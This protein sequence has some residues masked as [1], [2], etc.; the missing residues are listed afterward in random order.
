MAQTESSKYSQSIESPPNNL[1]NNEVGG[2]VR[3]YKEKAL[4]AFVAGGDTCLLG[5]KVPSNFRLLSLSATNANINEVVS[6]D[7]AGIESILDSDDSLPEGDTLAV[8]ANA[9]V[10]GTEDIVILYTEGNS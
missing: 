9:A 2:K 10:A 4:P 5:L 1:D 8:K 3:A 6:F 7:A